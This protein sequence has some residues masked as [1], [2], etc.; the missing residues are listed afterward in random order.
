M[1]LD[2]YRVAAEQL[3]EVYYMPEFVTSEQERSLIDQVGAPPSCTHW[4]RLPLSPSTGGRADLRKTECMD[5]TERTEAAEHRC[6]PG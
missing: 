6:P 3:D 2:G 1:D 5:T 4:C